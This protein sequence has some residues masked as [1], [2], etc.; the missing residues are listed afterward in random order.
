MAGKEHQEAESKKGG[1][2]MTRA[3]IVAKLKRYFKIK[4]LVCQHILAKFK[5]RED[6]AW[7]FLNKDLLEVLLW[8]RETLGKPITINK[9][10][11]A[12]QRGMRCNLCQMVKD[13]VVAYLSSH[14]L[15]S[16]IDFDVEGMTADEVRQWLVDNQDSLPHSIRLERDVTWVHLDVRN[17]TSEKIIW[18]DA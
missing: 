8:I 7:D 13:K 17:E 11:L 4:E 9:G 16:G 14:V 5:G 12:T 18:F 6:V 1:G 3:E 2:E 10:S 15:G